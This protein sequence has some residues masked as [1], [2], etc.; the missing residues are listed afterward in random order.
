MALGRRVGPLT[1]LIGCGLL[2]LAVAAGFAATHRGSD[3]SGMILRLG[4]LPHG[5]LNLELQEEQGDDVFCSRLTDPEDTPPKMARFVRRYH[6]RGCIG[7]Y[8]Q[9]YTLPGEAPG[10]AVAATGVLALQS[11]RAADASWAVVPEILGRL[12]GDRPPKEVKATERVGR[13]TR[14][15]HARLKDFNGRTGP[16]STTSFLVWRSGNTLAVVE[17]FGNDRAADDR[18]AAALARLQQ[19]HIRKP[20]RYT[21]AER[22]DGEVPLDDPAIDL[23][24]YWL[25]RN[26]RPGGDLAD[27]RLFD[28]GFSGKATKESVKPFREGAGAPLYIRYETIRLDTWSPGTWPVFTRS[29]TS[30]AITTWKCTETRTVALPEGSATIFGGY[31]RDYERC[32]KKQ[33]QAFT[34]WVD[35]GGVKVVVNSPPAPD[36]IETVNPY[37]TFAGM[38]AIVRGLT[39]RPKPV[40]SAA[41]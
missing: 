34:A 25:G 29:Q 16:V 35:V 28:S 13:A 40:Y 19:T 37:G 26:F 30:K 1:A 4:D 33:P 12:L 17:V 20:T 31:R 27:N 21:R 2:C 8:Y 24:V 22:F 39:L 7:A 11:D 10:P 6:P 3:Q 15:F 36:F 5:Y 18:M 41:P 38:E 23:P 32:P 14:L 9:L